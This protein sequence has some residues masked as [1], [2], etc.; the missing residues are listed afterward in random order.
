[1]TD[2]APGVMARLGGC[3]QLGGQRAG[4]PLRV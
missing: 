4:S 3:G 2:A 1:M